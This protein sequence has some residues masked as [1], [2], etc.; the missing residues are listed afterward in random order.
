MGKH[1]SKN[2]TLSGWGNYPAIEC[3]SFRPEKT[4]TLADLLASNKD[5]FIARGNGKSYGD[6]SLNTTATILT[7]R[8]DKIRTFNT[9]TGSVTVQ[10]GLLLSE[11]L[12]ITVPKGWIVPAIP[13][14]QHVSIGGM[15][16]CDVHGKNHYRDG[17][18][19]KHVTA[20]KLLLADGNH[21]TCTPEKHT[22]L[23]QA[24]LGGMGLTGIIEEVTFNLQP[25]QSTLLSTE[26]RTVESLEAMLALF[27][28]SKDTHEYRVGWIDHSAPKT[29]VG[30]GVFSK[31]NHKQEDDGSLANFAM[32]S[33]KFAIP[34][35]APQWLLNKHLMQLYN[36]QRF[37]QYS[38]EWK[39]GES[40]FHD[41]FHPLDSLGNWNKLYGRKG[42]LQHQCILPES[43]DVCAQLSELLQTIK[44]E[45]EFSFLAV[46]KHHGPH[47][48]GML[49]FPMAGYSLALDFPNTAKC[50]ELLERI[51]DKV[52]QWQGRI[53]L[54]KDALLTQE[55][56]AH[57]EST[58]MKEFQS[59]LSTLPQ[60]ERFSS[61][62]S[63]R[64]G[65]TPLQKEGK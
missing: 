28:E 9:Q 34:C 37:R 26:T 64:I 58:R 35:Y 43:V 29:S 2:Q 42:F 53:Y 51:T 10:A 13:G 46:L 39:Q 47:D 24:T 45:G 41:F 59:L 56:F 18:F 44:R 20:I 65:L 23:F 15:V 8:F 40:G 60:S 57:M 14:T 7:E 16:A 27:E 5:S 63:D 6:A 17:S 38:P 30:R 61:H 50:R 3:T 52:I 31:A 55:Q 21:K 25:I 11:L 48:S 12:S 33:P 32:R 54:A 4:K 36:W 22:D 19:G 1:P 62:L 49:S